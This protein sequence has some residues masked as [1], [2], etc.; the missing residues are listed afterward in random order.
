MLRRMFSTGLTH[1]TKDGKASMVN[2]GN[3]SFTLRVAKARGEIHV[4]PAIYEA[5]KANE[6]KKGDVFTVAKI[7]GI[8]SA[9]HTSTLIPLCHPINPE[10]IDVQLELKSPDTIVA[11][12]TVSLMGITGV[13]M[14]ALVATNSALLTVYDMCKAMSKN[15]TIQDVRLIYKSGGKSGDFNS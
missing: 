6:I 8:M 15:M 14:E 12:S 1:V 11:T 10:Y 13:E 5:V 3:K 2:V 7:A 4:G 9:K